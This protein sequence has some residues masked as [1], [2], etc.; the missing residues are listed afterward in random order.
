M[1]IATFHSFKPV[2]IFFDLQLYLPGFRERRTCWL[3]MRI[4][5]FECKPT[6]MCCLICLRHVFFFIKLERKENCRS[7]CL[8]CIRT[9]TDACLHLMLTAK[10]RQFASRWRQSVH[11]YRSRIKSNTIYMQMK[12]A[13]ILS[14]Y[15]CALF[16][17]LY[18]YFRSVG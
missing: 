6:C 4:W 16:L 5:C 18:T 3:R 17:V 13:S 8:C 9:S 14:H 15:S 7:V 2:S 10:Q 11:R 12:D 1:Y